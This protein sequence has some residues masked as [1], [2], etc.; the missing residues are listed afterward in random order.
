MA[1]EQASGK[2]VDKRADTWSFGAVLDEMLAGRKAFEGES[3]SDTLATVMKVEPD[4]SALP[5]DVAASVQK[6][7]RRCL[8]KDR[9]QRLQAI[10]DERIVLENPGG[11]EVRAQAESQ[12]RPKIP[13]VLAI[14]VTALL[15]VGLTLAIV[16]RLQPVQSADVMRF[17]FVLPKDQAFTN[18]GRHLIAISP[19]SANIVYV[20]DQ[21]LYLR[22]LADMEARPIPGMAMEKGPALSPFF[23]PDGRWVGFF[24]GG[25]IKK[26]AITG[27]AAV[28]LCDAMAPFGATWA[29]DDQI[30]FGQR[31]GGIMRVS[32][33]KGGKPERVVS[34]NPNETAQGPQLLPGGDLLLF[35]VARGVGVLQWDTAQIVA[36]SLKTGERHLILQGGSDARYAPTGHL[37]YALGS[38]LLAAPFD[39][40]KLQLAGAAAPIVDVARGR[41]TGAAQFAISSKGSMVYIPGVAGA[42]NRTVALVDAA[43]VRKPLDIQPGPH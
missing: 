15:A 39:L 40:R 22:S 12:P 7:V 23:S 20:A 24:S 11:T 31:E 4:W 13:W 14:A 8:T 1:P 17:S 36:Q 35:T 25:Q 18:Q 29:S 2:S 21:K 42:G 37:V 3:V 26:V 38:T 9:K 34:V 5:L 10:G 6:L 28:T 32:A 27:G 16:R 33:Q 43:G 19:D 30:Y 41:G